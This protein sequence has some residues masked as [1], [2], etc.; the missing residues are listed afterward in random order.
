MNMTLSKEWQSV[1]DLAV[2]MVEIIKDNELQE[3]NGDIDWGVVEDYVHLYYSGV[4]N[5]DLFDKAI[6][7]IHDSAEKMYMIPPGTTIH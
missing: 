2:A 5:N 1:V 4:V 7:L 6:A 3:A